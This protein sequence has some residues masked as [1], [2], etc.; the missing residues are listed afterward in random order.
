MKANSP[1]SRKI[2]AGLPFYLFI[3]DSFQTFFILLLFFNKAEGIQK[4]FVYPFL[5]CMFYTHIHLLRLLIFFQCIF[6]NSI[7]QSILL[8]IAF[9]V[10]A[11]DFYLFEY[12]VV[13]MI[14][15]TKCSHLNIFTTVLVLTIYITTFTNCFLTH[16]GTYK[17]IRCFL[18]KRQNNVI[19]NIIFFRKVKNCNYIQFV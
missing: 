12:F 1:K 2:Y 9:F 14:L 18:K 19:L 3:C 11:K 13:S 6:L 15:I 17:K 8:V 10:V 16:L 5:Q 7:L 4:S